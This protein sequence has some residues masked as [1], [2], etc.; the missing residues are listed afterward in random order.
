MANGIRTGDPRGFN[1]G[2][3]SKFPE[4]SRVRETPEEGKRTY[5]PKL[6]G[7]KN[8]D[9]NNSPKTFNDKNISVNN[10]DKFCQYNFIR[11]LSIIL[12]SV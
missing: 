3:S 10:S 9:E 11:I 1:K 7:N 8:K 4:G 12:T 6:C 2:R 5:R